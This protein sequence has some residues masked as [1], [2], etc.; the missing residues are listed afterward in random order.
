MRKK[1]HIERFC[2]LNKRLQEL[3]LTEEIFNKITA[4]LIES[5]DLKNS[6]QESYD[7][8]NPFQIEEIATTSSTSDS[9][10]KHINMLTRDQKL[11]LKMV[12]HIDKPQIQREYLEK[13]IKNIENHESPSEE[14]PFILYLKNPM[15]SLLS[16]IKENT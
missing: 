16:L 15:T 5:S 3:D 8:E 12:K 13:I 1:G 6:L 14:S 4:S 11:I 7:K 10:K 2:R 9:E